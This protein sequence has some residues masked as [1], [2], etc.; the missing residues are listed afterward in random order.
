[1]YVSA[2]YA[3]LLWSYEPQIVD[4]FFSRGNGHVDKLPEK[5]N[6]RAEGFGSV[7]GIYC[8]CLRDIE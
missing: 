1:M 6:K 5:D 8:A 7:L 2:S 4:W 3:Q